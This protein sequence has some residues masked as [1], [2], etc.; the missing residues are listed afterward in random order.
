M[1]V[2]NQILEGTGQAI[3]YIKRE[4]KEP[5]KCLQRCD[6]QTDSMVLS[7]TNLVSKNAFPR[8]SYICLIFQKIARICK[9]N[10]Y[11]ITYFEETYPNL[12]CSYI[13]GIDYKRNI[14]YLSDWPNT[15]VLKSNAELVN[16]LF[17]YAQNNLVFLEIFIKDP[18]YTK[19]K[20]DEQM[21]IISFIGNAGGLL[22]LC[23]GLSMISL[24]EVLYYVVA[25]LLNMLEH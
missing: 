9:S 20:R 6:F 10:F 23:M 21:T 11:R 5:V 15:N 13:R 2:Y 25:F 14:C 4:E 16:N 1:N 18:F 8:L 19:I 12:N 24:F 3:S 7:S 22:G 17:E